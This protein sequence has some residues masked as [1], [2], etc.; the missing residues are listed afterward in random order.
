IIDHTTYFYPNNYITRAEMAELIYRL[1]GSPEV[2][3]SNVYFLDISNT[4]NNSAIRYCASQGWINGYPDNTFKPYNYMTRDEVVTM[5]CRVLN[6]KY[7]NMSQKFSD[8]KPSYWAY[9]YIQ[10]ASSYV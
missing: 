7:G 3:T 6:R 1:M 4:Q 10:M 8:V 5:M 9:S 2:T